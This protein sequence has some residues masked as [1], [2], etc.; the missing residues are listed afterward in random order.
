MR[1]FTVGEHTYCSVRKLDVF[2]QSHVLRRLAPLIAGFMRSAPEMVAPVQEGDDPEQRAQAMMAAV[3]NNLDP[4]AEALTSMKDEDLDYVL[5]TCLAVLSRKMGK[6]R[7]LTPVVDSNGS[8]MFED[9]T[10]PQLYQLTWEVLQE[11]LSGFLIAPEQ[12][13]TMDEALGA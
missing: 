7:G 9:I 8:M 4:L 12:T 1:E 3:L 11:N 10:L 13:S 6:G 2:K 5:K